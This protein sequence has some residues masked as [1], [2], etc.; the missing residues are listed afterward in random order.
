M[1]LT[2]R[3]APSRSTWRGRWSRP[4]RRAS[5]TPSRAHWAAHRRSGTTLVEL[6][7]A[8]TLF[9]I[10][11][12]MV[13]A[14][15]RTSGRSLG[16]LASRL[17]ARSALW[18][19]TD[20]IASE[21]RPVSSSG[22]DLLLAADSAVWYAGLVA[23]GVACRAPNASTVDLLPDALASGMLV[24]WGAVQVQGGDA[25]RMLDEGTLAGDSDDRWVGGLILSV[26]ARRGLCTGTPYVDPVLDA[27]RVGYQLQLAAPLPPTVVAGAGL[28]VTRAARLALYRA[29][30]ADW[31]LGWTDWNVGSGAWNII[32]P[33]SGAY[34]PFVSAPGPSGLALALRDSTGM[35]IAPG[36]LTSG[37]RID[38]AL[39][40]QTSLARLGAGPAFRIVTDSL[41]THITL[42]NRQ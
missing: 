28:R 21:L 2:P 24:G 19:G 30:T 38:V 26:A 22:G 33:V 25:L 18:Q 4:W 12:A 7:V 37:A 17:E 27:G 40:T 9:S 36:S 3:R 15:L 31:W 1:R 32:Q 34:R 23:S 35:R 13:L 16:A 20:A 10:F 39:R 29:S 41:L 11:G 6:L 42:R 8:F 5:R 14:Q